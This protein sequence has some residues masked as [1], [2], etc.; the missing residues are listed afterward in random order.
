M[1][2]LRRTGGRV[3]TS[4]IS[5]CLKQPGQQCGTSFKW[6]WRSIAAEA[7]RGRCH[8][9]WLVLETQVEEARCQSS[10]YRKSPHSS[11][12]GAF[13]LRWKTPSRTACSGWLPCP[14]TKPDPP[15]ELCWPLWCPQSSFWIRWVWSLVPRELVLGLHR[16]SSAE[17]FRPGGDG[18]PFL[19]H[20]SAAPLCWAEPPSLSLCPDHFVMSASTLSLS[21]SPS[22]AAGVVFLCARFAAAGCRPCWQSPTWNVWF[23]PRPRCG[24][25]LPPVICTIITR[26]K[27]RTMERK[28][29]GGQWRGREGENNWGGRQGGWR[30]RSKVK[31]GKMEEGWLR[32]NEEGWWCNLLYYNK[33]KRMQPG[34]RF[35]LWRVKTENSKEY[36]GLMSQNKNVWWY[37]ERQRLKANWMD[38]K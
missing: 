11:Y 26:D 18:T 12:S 7:G 36:G 30:L 35:E 33:L 21:S 32:V 20:W 24:A 16:S 1:W 15:E 14:S 9:L 38:N 17:C 34:I 2:I 8:R 22:P 6:G 3:F 23:P 25:S 37:N 31:G 27:L 19:G 29:W 28:N 5:D 4:L 10:C 13:V